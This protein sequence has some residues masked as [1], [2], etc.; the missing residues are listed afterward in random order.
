MMMALV[1]GVIALAKRS[2]SSSQRPFGPSVSAI[3]TMTGTAPT[4]FAQPTKFGHAGLGTRI[5]S[6]VVSA[7]RMAICKACIPP[8]VQRNRSGDNSRS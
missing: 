4:T 2:V 7:I 6:P 5:S 8:M 3:G 1:F